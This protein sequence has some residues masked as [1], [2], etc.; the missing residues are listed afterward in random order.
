MINTVGSAWREHLRSGFPPT[1]RVYA[2]FRLLEY[3]D[4]ETGSAVYTLAREDNLIDRGNCESA[5][6]PMLLGE[7]V[8]VLTN[9]T[10][11]RS[12]DFAH[13]GTYA[14]KVT[15]TIAAGTA[16][17]V[18]LDDA[19]TTSTTDMHGLVAGETYEYSFWV[20]VPT[21]SGIA[22]SEIDLICRNYK[23]STTA[24]ST[25][26]D[27]SAP[28]ALDTWQEI[29]GSFTLDA[30]ATGFV[31]YLR[32]LSTA[33]LNEYFY[34]DD[35]R[36]TSHTVPGS[37]YL[38]SGYIETLCPMTETFT[39][40][41]KFKPTFAY[42]TATYY[43]IASWYVSGTQR[44]ALQWHAGN[45]YFTVRWYDGGTERYLVS[46]QYDN[47]T[48]FRNINQWITLTAAIDLSTGTTAG[49]SLWLDKTQ[50]DTTW[51]GNIDAKVTELNKLQIRAYN[52]TA[53][54]YDIAF[55]RYWPNRILT[56]AEVQNDAKDVANEEIFWSLDG[57]G[58]GR[59][60]ANITRFVRSITTTKNVE[61]PVNGAQTANLCSL[62]LNNIAGEFSD[63]QYAAF[64]PASDQFNGLVTQKYLQKRS[65][66]TIENWYGGDFDTVFFGKLTSGYERDTAN[67]KFGVVYI[68]AEDYIGLIARKTVRK[69]RYWENADLVDTA[70]ETDSLLHLIT[71][72]ATKKE[73]YNYLA[74]SSFENATIGDSWLVTAGGT[75]NRDAA[76]GF[77]G[78]CSGELIPGAANAQAYQTVTFTG[79]KKLNVGETWTFYVWLKSTAAATAVS[80]Y[81]SIRELDSIG[82]NDNTAQAYDLA[83]GEGY[84]KIEVSHTITDSDSDR[85]QIVVGADAGDTI[86]I[87]AAHLIQGDRALN[88]F[89]LN[90]NDGASGVESA[91][92]ADYDSYDTVGFDAQDVAIVHPWR[93]VEANQSIWGYVKDLGNATVA[94][95]VG[96]NSAGTLRYRSRLSSDYSDPV[97]MGTV[98]ETMGIAVQGETQDANRVIVHGVNIVKHGSVQILW[99]SNASNMV[100][101]STD[102]KMRTAVS[103]D[104]TWPSTSDYGNEFIAQYGENELPPEEEAAAPEVQD[105][106]HPYHGPQGVSAMQGFGNWLES[107]WDWYAGLWGKK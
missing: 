5:T 86:N 45:D 72:L 49:S 30:D 83:G 37:H 12:S 65:G 106:S 104:A 62:S 100:A 89:V 21:A 103:T 95:Y 59:T 58:T 73:V 84:T 32:M 51:S 47:G 16:A 6:A 56:N 54:A 13:G 82:M 105:W 101:M 66:L 39:L 81:I 50:D 96:L 61:N 87:D 93:R 43:T 88:Y 76:D 79:K 57:H 3:P 36:L 17:L 94:S 20:Y 22:V 41:I 4:L 46:A 23:S 98:D 2:D 26:E 75:L 69:G 97:P 99:D 71:R 19:Y 68:S 70:T 24:W 1:D 15:K 25:I 28:T 55:V 40:Q 74:N 31:I 53:G 92:D 29:S 34:V 10:F 78:S 48:A 77:F 33:A 64:A 14:F 63:D 102:G 42:D 52:G 90:D 80:N 107:I 35:I 85:L 18:S 91:D 60:R 11:A 7:T 44:L 38:S 9:T 8:P 27:S 67:D